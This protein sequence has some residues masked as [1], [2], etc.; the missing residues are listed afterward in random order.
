[1]YREF[2]KDY[3][4]G[5]SKTS[6]WTNPLSWTDNGHDDDVVLLQATESGLVQRRIR[7]MKVPESNL[8]QYEESEGPTKVDF[9]EDD[10]N[11]VLRE[12]DKNYMTGARKFHGW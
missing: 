5:G 12:A 7:E 1:M 10:Q 6:G 3:S 11:Q 8:L 4:I 9:G 2:D